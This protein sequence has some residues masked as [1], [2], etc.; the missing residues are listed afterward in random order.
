[1]KTFLLFNIL[2]F[3]T[4]L[5]LRP[6]N[7]PTTPGK[8]YKIWIRPTDRIKSEAGVLFQV[9]DSALVL[10]DS[11]FKSDYAKGDFSAEKWGASK[12]DIIKIRRQGAGFATLIGGITGLILGITLM[13]VY[14]HSLE[15]SMGSVDYVFKGGMMLGTLPL[16]LSTGIGIGTGVILA[17]K[18]TIPIRGKQ[19]NFDHYKGDLD[20]YSILHNTSLKTLTVVNGSFKRLMETVVDTDG[21]IYPTAALGGQVWLAGNLNVTHFNNG[22]AIPDLADGKNWATAGAASCWYRNDKERG[23]KSGKIYNWLAV[24]DS[25]GICPRGWHVSSD[26]EWSSMVTCLGGEIVAGEKMTKDIL[27]AA[28]GNEIVDNGGKP[29][30]DPCG[31]RFSNGEFSSENSPSYQWWTS[32]EQDQKLAKAIQIGNDGKDVF[33]TGS[34]KSTGLSVRCLKN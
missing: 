12:I 3:C 29:F 25:R 15:K 34:E 27:A 31:F 18:I 8:I 14:E 24:N 22:D 7:S 10:S 11:P 32:S 19:Q 30:A 6:Q 5:S 17:S 20:K 4:A 33:F 21:N 9:K 23:G 26:A 13:A 1:M 2:I 28:S 16:F